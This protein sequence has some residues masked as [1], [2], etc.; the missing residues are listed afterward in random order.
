MKN[1]FNLSKLGDIGASKK[2]FNK[3]INLFLNGLIFNKKL[4]EFTIKSVEGLYN[5]I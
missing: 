4:G 5:F 3:E 1:P 2:F